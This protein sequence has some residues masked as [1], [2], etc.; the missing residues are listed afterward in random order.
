M[1]TVFS[2]TLIKLRKEAGF[3]TAYSFFHDNG[4]KP[5]LKVSYRMYLLMEQGKLMPPFRSLGT[6]I[7]ALRLAPMSYS[8]VELTAAWLKVTLGE[9]EFNQLLAPFLKFPEEQSITSPLHKALQR[10]LTQRTFHITPGQTAVTTRSREN[11]LCWTALSNDT[12][13]WTPEALAA[14]LKLSPAAAQKAM[15]E[16]AAVK[17]LK[18]KNGAYRCPMVNSV[19]EYPRVL[20]NEITEK[21]LERFNDML[22]SAPPVHMRLGVIRASATELCNCFPLLSLNV[23]TMAT[24]NVTKKMEDS[25]IFAIETKVVKVRDF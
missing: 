2:E 24:Y 15:R 4:G 11:H 13:D 5:V 7:F 3:K 21:Y 10:E 18:F 6:Y 17:L 9:T 8:A 25:A 14:Q 1:G 16:L 20:P 19:I 22:S 23:T 12:G